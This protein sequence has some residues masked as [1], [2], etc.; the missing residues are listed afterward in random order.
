MFPKFILLH[1]H[2]QMQ[3]YVNGWCVSIVDP[4][5]QACRFDNKMVELFSIDCLQTNFPTSK[6]YKG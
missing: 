6:D 2:M 3:I 1:K 4:V 5:R